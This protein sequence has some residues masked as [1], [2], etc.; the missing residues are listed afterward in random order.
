[1]NLKPQQSSFQTAELISPEADP[2]FIPRPKQNP[3]PPEPPEQWTQVQELNVD[4]Q[5]Q[6]LNDVQF[7]AYETQSDARFDLEEYSRSQSGLLIAPAEADYLQS[8]WRNVQ[9]GFVDEPRR[10]IEQADQLIRDAI[11]QVQE[12][13]NAK[14]ENLKREW[15]EKEEASTEDLRLVLQ[16]YRSMFSRLLSI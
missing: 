12:E 16:K 15:S 7:D 6:D 5:T 9:I 8:Q 2:H 1:M 11:L 3:G 14:R 4:S 10:A 13:F